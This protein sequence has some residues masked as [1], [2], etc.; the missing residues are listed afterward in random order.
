MLITKDIL[1]K[2]NEYGYWIMMMPEEDHMLISLVDSHPC[3]GDSIDYKIK[4]EEDL[5]VRLKEII[6]IE[7]GGK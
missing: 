6:N 4:S 5:A 3:H 2:L 1:D 7:F